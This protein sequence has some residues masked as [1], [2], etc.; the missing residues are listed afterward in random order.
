MD[1][2][3]VLLVDDE[4]EL[5]FTVVERLLL[6]DIDA[7]GVTSSHEALE[8]IKEEEFDVV[9]LDVK[10]PGMDGLEL[11]KRVKEIRPNTQVILVTGRGSE[12]DFKDGIEAGAYDYLVKPVKLET[13]IEKMHE[14]KAGK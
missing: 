14:I 6:R 11:L 4:G 3:S 12:Q 5:I 7:K 13:L 8:C 1:Q 10:M 9:V 2:L